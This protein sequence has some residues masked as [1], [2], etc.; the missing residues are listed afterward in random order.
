MVLPRMENPRATSVVALCLL[1]ILAF[2]VVPVAAQKAGDKA[3]LSMDRLNWGT[4]N[5]RFSS[6]ETAITRVQPTLRFTNHKADTATIT[7]VEMY[8]NPELSGKFS[9]E[10][11]ETVAS[12][13]STDIVIRAEIDKAQKT[14]DYDCKA[15]VLVTY[16]GE[17]YEI[18]Y[19]KIDAITI[20]RPAGGIPGFPWES[21][22]MG[23][24]IATIVVVSR[25]RI[26]R[27]PVV[28]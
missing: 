21:I 20:Y 22:A 18:D 11:S 19:G 10:G 16:S 7:K 24:A 25:R 28:P 14:G 23:L 3:W 5:K 4:T 15:R 17:E 1:T 26:L 6:T 9:W 27:I 12:G 8:F 2:S 13:A